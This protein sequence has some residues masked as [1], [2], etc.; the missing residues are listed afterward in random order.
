MQRGEASRLQRG[1]EAL[2]ERS[3]AE[4]ALFGYA[5]SARKSLRGRLD[6][7][8]QEDSAL[9]FE[10]NLLLDSASEHRRGVGGGL[11]L[12]LVES[13]A[14][15]YSKAAYLKKRQREFEYSR[16]ARNCSSRGG[17]EVFAQRRASSGYFCAFE[18]DLASKFKSGKDV[19][20]E[21]SLL[22]CPFDHRYRNT[23]SQGKRDGRESP[24]RTDVDERVPNERQQ[25][26]TVEDMRDE[27]FGR[28]RTAEIEPAICVQE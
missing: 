7:A 19:L 26:Q 17:S 1:I 24:A 11:A 12:T 14:L 15:E 13:A 18:N 2:R 22:G 16:R 28:V 6:L 23:A 27:I 3:Q 9:S 10:R 4:G 21:R 5:G 8:N 25:R 20:Q